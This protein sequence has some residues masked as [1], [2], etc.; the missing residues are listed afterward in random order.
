MFSVEFC[1]LPEFCDFFSSVFRIAENWGLFWG[2]A[3]KFYVH[4]TLG[5]LGEVM[6]TAFRSRRTRYVCLAF[7][8]VQEGYWVH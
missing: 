8:I 1:V 6:T 5:L 2:W 3:F 7:L 4:V